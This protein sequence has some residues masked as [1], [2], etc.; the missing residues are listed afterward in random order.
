M[1]WMGSLLT[2]R[3]ITITSHLPEASTPT[4]Q[5]R[6]S[7]QQPEPQKA[8]TEEKLTEPVK[9]ELKPPEPQL[10]VIAPGETAEIISPTN[11][12]EKKEPQTTS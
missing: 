1:G 6:E 2:I 9:P 7:K 12:T 4:T 10:L 11:Q 5:K 8:K 3:G